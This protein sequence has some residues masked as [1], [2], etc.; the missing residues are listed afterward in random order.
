M[1]YIYI[2]IFIYLLSLLPSFFWVEDEKPGFFR[3]WQKNIG[4][5]EIPCF[6][7][8]SGSGMILSGFKSF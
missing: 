1:L 5:S 6:L 2:Y 4:F 8:I 7:E 3:N